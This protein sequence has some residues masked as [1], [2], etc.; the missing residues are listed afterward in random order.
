[1]SKGQYTVPHPEAGEHHMKW[2]QEFLVHV[3][4]MRYWQKQYFLTRSASALEASKNYERLVDACIKK[5]YEPE[6][7]LF[8]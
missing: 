8:K 3:R 6:L 2:E 7:N 1:M 4:N 5:I